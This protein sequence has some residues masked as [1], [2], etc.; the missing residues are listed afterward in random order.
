MTTQATVQ[1]KETY[2]MFIGGQFVDSESGATFNTY[3]PA[4]GEV[5]AKVAKGSKKDVDLA[6]EAARK[7]FDHSR[8]PTMPVNKRSRLLNKIAQIMRKRFDELVELEVLN[9]GK[10]LTA[11]QG[12]VMQAIEDFEFYAGAIV[13][14]GGETKPVPPGFF[15]YTQ[16]EPVGV[17]AQVIPWNYPLMMA[18]WKIAPALAAGCTIVLKPASLTPIT[19]LVL[20]EICHEAGVPEGVLNVVTGPGAEIGTYLVEHP[21]VDK[22]AFTGETLTGKDIMSKASETLKRVTLELGGKSANIVFDDAD[23]EAAV[24]GSLFGIFYNT[25]QSC[26]ARSR[27]FVH[28]SI[29]DEF[30]SRFVEKAK[31]LNL[32]D[33]LSKATH[34]GAVISQRQLEVIDAYVQE[35]VKEGAEIAYG[36]YRPSIEGFENGYWYMP[37]ILTNVTND[38]KVAQEEIFG[39][40]VVVMPFK[41]EKEAIQLANDTIYGLAGAVWTKDHA[42]AHRVASGI[43]AGVIMVN[44]PF[45]AF[46]GLPFGGYKQSGFG[47]EL[48]L[49]TLDLYTETKSVLSYIGPKPLNPFGV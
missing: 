33:P 12:Q 30:L 34:V 27:L 11:A 29:Y 46:P 19:A 17:C 14:Y 5:L 45:S 18:A 24:D 23:L 35:A 39:P 42:R 25:G 16:K 2:Q 13:S 3:N 48:A 40:V 6:V 9:S 37:T 8:W 44:C 20:A 36:G 4:T 7:A 43:R 32:G 38:M 47:R 22:V 21:G 41:D 1:V 31:K 49:E 15:N 28:D 10:A 26:E